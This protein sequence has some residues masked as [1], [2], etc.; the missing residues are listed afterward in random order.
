V[1]DVVTA[2]GENW[3]EVDADGEEKPRHYVPH[4]RGNASGGHDKDMVAKIK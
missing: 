1:T 2:K 4:L 3:I